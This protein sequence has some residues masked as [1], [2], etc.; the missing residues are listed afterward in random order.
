M[1]YYYT[2]Y[3]QTVKRII[4]YMSIVAVL[5]LVGVNHLFMYDPSIN[6][7]GLTQETA[8]IYCV[9][10]LVVCTLFLFL[11]SKVASSSEK[12][13]LISMYL[14]FPIGMGALLYAPLV[15]YH[16]GD[17]PKV[18]VKDEVLIKTINAYQKVWARQCFVQRFVVPILMASALVLIVLYAEP[19]ITAMGDAALWVF[20]I[21]FVLVLGATMW[22]IGAARRIKETTDYYSPTTT[23]GW[24]GVEEY[25]WRKT[26]SETKEKTEVSVLWGIVAI[27]LSIFLMSLAVVLVVYY[28]FFQV[29]RIFIPM[30]G[31]RT[32][33]LH[34]RTIRISSDYIP[35]A[36]TA[37]N[38][39]FVLL[40][41]IVGFIF[42]YNYVNQDFWTEGIGASYIEEHLSSRNYDY[43]QKLLAKIEKKH[44]YYYNF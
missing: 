14:V 34:K 1:E 27:P 32:I 8:N 29:I 37:F 6:W 44:G 25:E 11:L 2:F 33:F 5:V 38:F 36:N 15:S 17:T 18:K 22:L 24:F 35:A 40:N 39:I 12:W 42:Q 7:E 23:Y 19:I 43:L 20:G 41:H 21:I 28:V 3:M 30:G 26:H 31:R 9:I 16:R 4:I 10:G 13:A